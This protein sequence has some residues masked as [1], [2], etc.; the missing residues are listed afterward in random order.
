MNEYLTNIYA[1]ECVEAKAGEDHQKFKQKGL[2]SVSGPVRSTNN[3][4]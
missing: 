1:D 4:L 3:R 2:L